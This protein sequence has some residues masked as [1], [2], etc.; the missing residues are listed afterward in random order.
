MTELE[1]EVQG[2]LERVKKDITTTIE[3]LKINTQEPLTDA[4]QFE[5]QTK[6][7]ITTGRDLHELWVVYNKLDLILSKAGRR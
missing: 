4:R 3:A 7:I 1:K 2:Q 5:L 6:N